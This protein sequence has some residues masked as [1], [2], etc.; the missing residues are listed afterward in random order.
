VEAQCRLAVRDLEREAAAVRRST[1][2]ALRTAGSRGAVA[3]GGGE[4][5]ESQERTQSGAS[6]DAS[7]AV[8]RG[9]GHA[10]PSREQCGGGAG[11]GP[12]GRGGQGARLS[13]SGRGGG[14]RAPA[15]TVRRWR[16]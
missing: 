11:S 1:V 6:A 7:W 12:G 9:E 10:I 2:R 3:A 13:R 5:D 4:A 14:G 8:C 15:G 16:R